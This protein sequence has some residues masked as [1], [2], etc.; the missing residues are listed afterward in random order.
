MKKRIDLTGK[1]V[2]IIGSGQDLNGR[3]LGSKID[4]GMFADYI[5]RVNK[6]YGDPQ[7]VGSKTDLAFV[8]KNA[9]QYYY[10]PAYVHKDMDVFISEERD[11][12]ED[13]HQRIANE[14]GVQKPSCGAL[15]VAWARAMNAK[16]ITIVGFGWKNGHWPKQK[17]YPD[18]TKDNNPE[19]DWHKEE[20]WLEKQVSI[21]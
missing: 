7:D 6:P 18:G 8:R 3:K 17:T 14:I 15:A 21:I 12:T 2:L 19:Y 5:I 1:N 11:M 9:F 4:S 13:A 20:Q 16:S 10:F